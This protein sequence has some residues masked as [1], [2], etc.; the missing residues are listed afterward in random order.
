M[1]RDLK[2]VGYAF[3]SCDL[4][5]YIPDGENDCLLINRLICDKCGQYWH[6]NLSECYFCGEINY[7]LYK[8]MDCGK[9][10]SIT[11]AS[12]KCDCGSKNI[13]KACVN[14]NCPS[15]KWDEL[16]K[17]TT[18]KKGVFELNSSFNVSLTHCVTCGNKSNK[19]KSY[20]IYVF[21]FKDNKNKELI[22]YKNKKIVQNN[23]I[24]L[25]KFK[26]DNIIKYDYLTFNTSEDYIYKLEFNTLKFES[27][28]A[29]V[30]ELYPVKAK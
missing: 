10:H 15:N 8:C 3:I 25:V 22:N 30:K 2:S 7:Y 29:L 23:D 17:V 6:T 20:R 13:V 28:P 21:N 16:S 26:K 5:L 11:N 12:K 19:Y 14:P 1:N 4:E 9:L 24:V 27:I 18:S